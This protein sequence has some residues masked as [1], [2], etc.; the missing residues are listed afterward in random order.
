M[1]AVPA[2]CTALAA[3]VVIGAVD[4]ALGATIRV[5]V[6]TIWS[7]P[8]LAPAGA[9]SARAGVVSMAKP[10]AIGATPALT[11]CAIVTFM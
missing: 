1:R 2:H 10:S 5:P 11:A 6:T 4:T 9:S 3:M 7:A 8:I